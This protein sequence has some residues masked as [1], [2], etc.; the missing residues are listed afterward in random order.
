MAVWGQGSWTG[1]CVSEIVWR[2]SAVHSCRVKWL[3]ATKREILMALDH[4][5]VLTAQ[6]NTTLA[7]MG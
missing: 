1:K 6:V 7:L 3:R 4:W 2:S 5:V